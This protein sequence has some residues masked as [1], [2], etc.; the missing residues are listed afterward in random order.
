MLEFEESEDREAVVGLGHP[1]YN[2][3]C[4]WLE[5]AKLTCKIC[6]HAL[7]IQGLLMMLFI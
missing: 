1:S 4:K 7:L 3:L 6:L 2:V 5:S